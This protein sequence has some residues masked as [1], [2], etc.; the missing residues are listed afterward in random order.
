MEVAARIG[1]CLKKEDIL[2]RI[3]GDEFCI[4]VMDTNS[5]D[6]YDA[7][8]RRIVERIS[9][10]YAV[11][12]IILYPGISCGYSRFPEDQSDIEKL[13]QEADRNMYT[14]KNM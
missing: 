1:D 2:F 7:L 13:I 11:A 8:I 3:G 10:P 12:D 5:G 4:V 9:R 14:M 6:F